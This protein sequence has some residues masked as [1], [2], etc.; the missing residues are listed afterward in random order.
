[1]NVALANLTD[2]DGTA[3]PDT[4]TIAAG[5]SYGGAAT[6]KSIAVTA[7]G[8]PV[9][10]APSTLNLGAGKPGAVPGVSLGESGATSGEIFT[11]TVSDVNGV[12]SAGTGGGATVSGPGTTLTI[13]GSLAQVNAA[14]STLSDTDNSAGPDTIALNAADSLGNQ[15][16]ARSIAVSVTAGPVITAPGGAV[17]GVGKVASIPGI[18]V[19][20]SSLWS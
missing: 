12:L 10:A 6:Q 18:S 1:V 3:G 5:E 13:S 8:L 4:I 16:A 2:T 19:S 17:I 7:N 20:E 15:A 14:L 9:I 11:V